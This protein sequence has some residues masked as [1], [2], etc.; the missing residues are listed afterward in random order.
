MTAPSIREKWESGDVSPFH[1]WN[2]WSPDR[3]AEERLRTGL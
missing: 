3:V 2:R 1:G